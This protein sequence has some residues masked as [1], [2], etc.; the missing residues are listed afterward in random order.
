MGRMDI[1]MEVLVMSSYVAA[2]RYGH[3]LQ[4]LHIF[5]YL[6][7]HHDARLVFDPSYPKI[8]DEQFVRRNWDGFY[9]NEKEA[10]L[11][12]R[13]DEREKEFII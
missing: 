1:R 2:P 4:V 6:M 12:N 11:L 9:G 5:A 7:C 8:D 3:L 13:P 10:I